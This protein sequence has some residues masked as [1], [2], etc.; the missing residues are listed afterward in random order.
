MCSP[1]TCT[2]TSSW[3]LPRAAIERAF[4]LDPHHPHAFDSLS[5]AQLSVCNWEA[6]ARLVPQAEGGLRGNAGPASLVYPLYY[7]GNQAY[8]L[9]AAR[10]YLQ[11]NC[12][13]VRAPLPARAASEPSKLRIAYLSS[14]FR[15]HPVAAA[16]VELLERHDRSR[17]EILGVSL[18]RDDA[19]E[20]RARLM[21]AFDSFH[22]VADHSDRAVAESLR[23]LD[24]LWADWT[25]VAFSV[26]YAFDSAILSALAS[27]AF[28][29]MFRDIL[30]AFERRADRLFARAGTAD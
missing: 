21:R 13:P 15:F 29:A 2:S 10:A 14:D 26:D 24:V 22:D 4:A 8:Q 11:A 6:V 19:S 5:F 1:R 27:R 12:P 17:F 20:I 18:G 28:A 16:I 23:R 3:P 30:T 9:T 7:F 25:R